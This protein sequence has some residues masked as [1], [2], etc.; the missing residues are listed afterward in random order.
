[1]TVIEKYYAT[2]DS[3]R[4]EDAMALLAADVEFTMV[5][6]GGENRGR[7]RDRMLEYLRNR[8]PVNRKHVVQRTAGDR[9]LEFAQGKVT[10]NDSTTTG[11]FVGVM[12]LDGHGLV[13]RYQVT[14]SA[15]FALIPEG[16]NP[17]EQEDR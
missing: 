7:G 5:L 17:D 8:P 15:D 16:S 10:E 4:L 14:F 12:H 13:D 11:F 9:D 2:V 3:G 6:P 1:M